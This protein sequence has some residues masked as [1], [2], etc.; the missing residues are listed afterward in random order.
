MES[1]QTTAQSTAYAFWK[2]MA[3]GM[4]HQIGPPRRLQAGH[5]N[6]QIHT[7][8]PNRCWRRCGGAGR[9]GL[10]R[11]LVWLRRRGEQTNAARRRRCKQRGRIPAQHGSASVQAGGQTQRLQHSNGRSSTSWGKSPLSSKE[12]QVRCHAPPCASGES[13]SSRIHTTRKAKIEDKPFDSIKGLCGLAERVGLGARTGQQ[14]LEQLACGEA[15]SSA[16]GFASACGMLPG[17]P[18]PSHQSGSGRTTS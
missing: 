16:S 10:H 5:V 4:S 3:S 14:L 8:C 7:G 17:T 15:T 9:A 6:P 13:I 2:D 11:R 18:Q 12:L 1:L